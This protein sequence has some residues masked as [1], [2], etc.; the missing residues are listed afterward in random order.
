M[1]CAV[2]QRQFRT[3][4]A[5][6][7]HVASD[8]HAKAEEE[9][10]KDRGLAMR[11]STSSFISDFLSYVSQITKYTEINQ[12]YRQYLAKNRFRIEGTSLKNMEAVV[13]EL[14]GRVSVA[15]EDNKIMV[16]CLSTSE[17]VRKPA[18][19]DL[20]RIGLSFDTKTI[21]QATPVTRHFKNIF[22]D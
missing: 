16:K 15:R 14:S 1:F 6:K 2:C 11:K 17:I 9:C 7:A 20:S 22:E 21:E 3:K 8:A 10:K 19:F 18:V 12:L 4:N 5:Y 13:D